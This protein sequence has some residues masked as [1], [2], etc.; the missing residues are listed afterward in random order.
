MAVVLD[1]KERAV[2]PRSLK[3]EIRAE[4]EVPAV[5]HG[6]NIESTAIT[7]DEK[8]LIQILRKYGKN[9]VITMTIDGKKVNSL[10]AEQQVDTFTKKWIHVE[11]I[12]V[13]MNEVTEVEAEIV[14]I[15]EAEGVKSGGLLVQNL[16][17]AKVSATPDKLPESI[18]VDITK[19]GIGETITLGDLPVE[20]DFEIIGDPEEQ[21]VI[22]S[23][24]TVAEE[25]EVSETVAEPALVEKAKSEE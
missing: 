7:V 23:E 12:A 2:R 11:F 13:D 17:T 10:L 6:N 1:V 24:R 21:I 22:I 5:V 3:K 25:P 20:K 8:Q 15:G 14:L 4:G 18:E 19:L 9:A 16:Y